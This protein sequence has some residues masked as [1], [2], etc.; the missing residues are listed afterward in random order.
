MMMFMIIM[1]MIMMI[2]IMMIIRSD[3]NPGDIIWRALM[4]NLTLPFIHLTV[5]YPHVFLICA[6]TVICLYLATIKS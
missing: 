2:M 5:H 4:E 3:G 1:I 6:K